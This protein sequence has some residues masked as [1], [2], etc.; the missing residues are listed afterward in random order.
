MNMDPL[1]ENHHE[2]NPYMYANNNPII[3]VDPDG[4]DFTLTGVAAQDFARGLQGRLSESEASQNFGEDPPI[5]SKTKDNLGGFAKGI[6]NGAIDTTISMNPVY[7]AGEQIGKLFDKEFELIPRTA[8]SEGEQN[9][10][11][12]G[13]I[14]LAIIEPGPNGEAR[15][16]KNIASKGASSRILSWGNNAKGHLIKHADALG[17]G[18]HSTQQLQ[19]MLT[20]LRGAANQLYNNVNPALTK[21]GVWPGQTDNVLMHITNNGKMLVTKLNGEFITAINKTSNSDYVKA[22]PY[23]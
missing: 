1:A 21:I 11:L 17:F 23:K 10:A 4:K 18:S 13:S 8:V 7:N 15:I 19:K 20:E 6:L 9:A 3:F 5:K 16:F 22:L 2:N 12:A 14:F